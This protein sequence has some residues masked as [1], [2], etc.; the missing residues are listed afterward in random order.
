MSVVGIG[1]DLAD[2]DRIRD[3]FERRGE[4]FLRRVFTPAEAAYARG[5]HDPAP[6]L[7]ARFAAKEAV[8]KALGQGWPE[9]M[10]WTDLEVVR[11]K[12]SP[13]RLVLHG[14]AAEAAEKRGVRQ[15]HLSL[16]HDRGTA[17]AMVVL[18][19]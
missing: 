9:G 13:P 8:I 11:E 6:S 18:E 19:G 14:A 3:L 16:S 10:R 4:T 7:A 15:T 1:V 2:I 17:V 12:G 5:Q